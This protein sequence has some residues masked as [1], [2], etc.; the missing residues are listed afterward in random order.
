[1]I[2]MAL[3]A[4]IAIVRA[5][6]RLYTFGLPPTVRMARRGEIDSDVWESVHDAG[7]DPGLALHVI[8]R[9]VIGIPDDLT[10]RTEQSSARA[11]RRWAVGLA[12]GAIAMLS[13][14]VGREMRQT[15]EVPE[16]EMLE[17]VK[18]LEKKIEAERNR[19]RAIDVPPPPPPPPCL[20]R[21]FPQD[22]SRP[23]SR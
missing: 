21:G 18:E 14:W 20:P 2:T 11:A 10:W 12:F 23:C 15:A 1:M 22:R 4:A 3:R 5:W 7:G 17:L 6:T 16:T 13:L 19:P 8:A 9:L